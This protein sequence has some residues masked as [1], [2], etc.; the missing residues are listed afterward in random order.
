VDVKEVIVSATKA[1]L[2]GINEAK[3]AL[4]DV[5]QL[6]S[7]SRIELEIGINPS[8]EVANYDDVRIAT[9]TVSIPLTNSG[10]T[11]ASPAS[12]ALQ[13]DKKPEKTDKKKK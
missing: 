6:G 13:S 4:K 3:V 7:P 11:L 1:V 8:Y 9:V 5:T 12:E 10:E 2:E